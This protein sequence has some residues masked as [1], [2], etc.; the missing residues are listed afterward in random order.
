MLDIS[1][2]II[3]KN[4]ASD[5]AECIKSA[6]TIS[7][8]IVVTDTGSID[9]TTRIAKECGA[10]VV[11]ATWINYGVARNVGA[12]MAKHDWII[13]LDADERIT[14]D[15][16]EAIR[17]I[18]C[19]DP[20]LAFGF[21]RKNYFRKKRIRFGDWGHDIVYRL[22]NRTCSKWQNVPV[23]EILQG[24]NLVKRKIQGRLLHYTVAS[25]HEY[26]NKIARYAFLSAG[27][28]MEQKR[29]PNFFKKIF[30][31]PVNFMACYFLRLGFLDGKEGF[32]IAVYTAWYSYLKYHYFS[33][34]YKKTHDLNL[35]RALSKSIVSR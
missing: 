16:A 9:C 35:G 4:E 5:I 34:M 8:D 12:A 33:E 13:A 29:R 11:N 32:I 21:E 27:K 10:H 22:Y 24:D 6:R 20:D 15:L 30:S 7:N 23:H 28:Y 2:V 19:D 26:T 14:P 31:A 3:A 17:R 18:D 1:I 25:M